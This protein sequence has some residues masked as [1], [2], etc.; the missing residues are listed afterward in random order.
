MRLLVH[1]NN[2]K[3]KIF[4]VR[5]IIPAYPNYKAL[6]D[7]ALFNAVQVEPGGYGVAWNSELDASEG[8]LWQNGILVE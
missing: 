5:Q 6:E 2:G 4:D 8:E 3:K 1:F 7:E